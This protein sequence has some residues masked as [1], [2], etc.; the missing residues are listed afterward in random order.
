MLVPMKLRDYLL[1]N[2]ETA[3]AFA[4]RAGLSQS[5]VSRILN[6]VSMPSWN[7]ISLISIATDGSVTAND[8]A[9]PVEA[10]E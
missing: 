6:G 4:E 2:D 9:Q 7:T 1:L 5:Q 8:F 3:S 10:A